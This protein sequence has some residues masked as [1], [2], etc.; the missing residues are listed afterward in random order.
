MQSGF[1]EALQ[2]IELGRRNTI[3]CPFFDYMDIYI[4]L[5]CNMTEKE[6]QRLNRRELLEMLIS[7][8]EKNEYL[9]Q[10]L[11]EAEEKLSSRQIALQNAG[12]IAEASLQLNNVFESAQAAAA[13]YLENIAHM[14]EQQE[15]IA[16][17]MNA[18]ARKQA[19]AIV[20]EADAYS[21]KTRTEADAYWKQ[22]SD[23]I[24]SLL[25]QQESLRQLLRTGRDDL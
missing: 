19:A 24:Q 1:S 23:K 13:Q 5:R 16:Q 2:K 7:Q 22:V 15:K 9:Q 4:G 17:R 3:R 21:D 8:M 11:E 18:E 6:L 25:Q 20:A 10:K 14:N 12:S